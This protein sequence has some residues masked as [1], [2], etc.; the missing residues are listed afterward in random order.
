MDGE[1]EAAAAATGRTDEVMRKALKGRISRP[2][3]LTSPGR[4]DHSVVGCM[5]RGTSKTP[6]YSLLQLRSRLVTGDRTLH[7]R[8]LHH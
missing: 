6:R 4:H 1:R 8:P 2:A 5:K 7:Q 3:S